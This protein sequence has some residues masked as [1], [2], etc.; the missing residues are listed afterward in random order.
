MTTLGLDQQAFLPLSLGL[1]YNMCLCEL[2]LNL[3]D[4]SQNC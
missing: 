3:Y 4:A 2:G 1:A